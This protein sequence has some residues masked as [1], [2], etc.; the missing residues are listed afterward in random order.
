[1]HIEPPGE[2]L[3]YAEETGRVGRPEEIRA[4]SGRCHEIDS[5]ST[6]YYINL[7]RTHTNPQN[8][9][10][11]RVPGLRQEADLSRRASQYHR[12]Q[13]SRDP[14]ARPGRAFCILCVKLGNK[15]LI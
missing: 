14:T 11:S 10:T 6:A 1:M 7:R 13:P 8:P 5:E 15:I 2:V 9:R 4:F 12:L 3:R